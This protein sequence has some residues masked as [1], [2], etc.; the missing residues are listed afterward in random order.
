MEKTQLNLNLSFEE[1]VKMNKSKAHKIN[2]YANK[3]SSSSKSNRK[4]ALFRLLDLDPSILK[5]FS[6]T[7]SFFYIKSN[8]L[9]LAGPEQLKTLKDHLSSQENLKRH[10][11]IDHHSHANY[12]EFDE[13][14]SIQPHVSKLGRNYWRYLV[15]M[16]DYKE[17][18]DPRT[19]IFW[20]S[21]SGYQKNTPKRKYF[22]SQTSKKFK[23]K[24]IGNLDNLSRNHKRK[25]SKF[26]ISRS[27]KRKSKKSQTKFSFQKNFQSFTEKCDSNEM[28]YFSP[29]K[30]PKQNLLGLLDSLNK[31]TDSQ[32]SKNNSP[33]FL[34]PNN[35]KRPSFVI[36][37]KP[38]SS[39][40]KHSIQN[41]RLKNSQITNN[42]KP[43]IGKF[44]LAVRRFRKRREA[45]D[46]YDR[47]RSLEK[48]L[49][50]IE[51]RK[52]SLL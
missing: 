30:K 12:F 38:T 52:M 5:V 37:K 36:K 11:E 13:F 44:E 21:L 19:N 40:F 17:L 42:G 49:R 1:R 18:P 9:F 14:G 46:R 47:A 29:Q 41:N 23:S 26:R 3:L 48:K 27:K 22:V 45:A 32:I 51:S 8:W 7:Q 50:T 43:T 4:K 6:E 10:M 24:T 25:G 34:T 33:I 39:K 2:L 15:D 16:E 20:I 28:S 31:R 35:K